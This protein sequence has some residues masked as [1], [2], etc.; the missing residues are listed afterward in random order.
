MQQECSN[1]NFSFSSEGLGA[2]EIYK[3]GK[4]NNIGLRNIYFV[5]MYIKET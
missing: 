4:D 5:E 2:Q 3:V 1:W